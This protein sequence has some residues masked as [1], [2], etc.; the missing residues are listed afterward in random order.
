M[1]TFEYRIVGMCYE[2]GRPDTKPNIQSLLNSMGKDGWELVESRP[3]DFGEDIYFK[4]I[5]GPWPEDVHPGDT[6]TTGGT[7]FD[8]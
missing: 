7:K 6:R 3:T 4:R 1:D 5:R 2:R 8:S